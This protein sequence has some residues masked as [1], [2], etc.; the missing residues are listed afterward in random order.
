MGSSN[1]IKPTAENTDITLAK[2][3]ERGGTTRKDGARDDRRVRIS[4]REATSC[5]AVSLPMTVHPPFCALMSSLLR[6]VS[7][8]VRSPRTTSWSRFNREDGHHR[9]GAAAPAWRRSSARLPAAPSLRRRSP[10]RPRPPSLCRSALAMVVAWQL[11]LARPLP[12]SRRL[13]WNLVRWHAE[14]AARTLS[15][16]FERVSV[17]GRPVFR[18]AVCAP[19]EGG[20]TV[21]LRSA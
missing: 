10:S 8:L 3:H 18:E 14:G 16:V 11:P 17:S 5:A 1:K 19:R 6:Q 9:L 7:R 4:L 2:H 13:L 20:E 21:V 12:T 15:F